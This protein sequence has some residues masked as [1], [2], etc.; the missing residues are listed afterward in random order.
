M[1][2]S[3]ASMICIMRRS[4][5]SSTTRILLYLSEILSLK[6]AADVSR[7]KTHRQHT[8][9][10][11]SVQKSLSSSRC[12]WHFRDSG[13]PVGSTSVCSRR[14]DLCWCSS[15]CAGHSA[16][17]QVRQVLTATDGVSM[18]WSQWIVE[19]DWVAQLGVVVRGSVVDGLFAAK[20]FTLSD[21]RGEEYL[22]LGAEERTLF[23]PLRFPHSLDAGEAEVVSA[24]Q[25]D[26]TREQI[27]ANWTLESFLHS[28]HR[29]AVRSLL[30][31]QL[32]VE[33]VLRSLLLMNV[34][35]ASVGM[36]T[37]LTCLRSQVTKDEMISYISG[38]RPPPRETTHKLN[39]TIPMQLVELRHPKRIQL[40]H[41]GLRCSSFRK[42]SACELERSQTGATKRVNTV[43]ATQCNF[44]IKPSQKQTSEPP[45]ELKGP[46]HRG[47]RVPISP[48]VPSYRGLS[49]SLAHS[50]RLSARDSLAP[51]P[52]EREQQGIM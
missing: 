23:R 45:R 26:G 7:K 49:P 5:P 11:S 18:Q 28:P 51:L 29:R 50:S 27:L 3:S 37:P 9:T 34:S 52:G 31:W 40:W 6:S 38:F 24:W 36:H 39:G 16:A 33:S 25:R 30:L 22:A 20:S 19:D 10:I 46:Y 8:G 47:C 21:I 1:C 41:D 13:S 2:V 14:A 43:V 48:H 32:G 42:S 15:A 35:Q 12:S 17:S 44:L 4:S